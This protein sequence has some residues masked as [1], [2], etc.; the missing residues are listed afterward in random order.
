MSW[1][2]QYFKYNQKGN[3]QNAKVCPKKRKAAVDKVDSEQNGSDSDNL[4]FRVVEFLR[5]IKEPGCRKVTVKVK[6]LDDG[7]PGF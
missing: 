1:V 5:H 2:G 3:F 6:V 4:V 7:R